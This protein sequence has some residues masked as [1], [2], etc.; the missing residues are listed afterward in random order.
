MKISFTGAGMWGANPVIITDKSSG[1][2][3]FVGNTSSKNIQ[4]NT[5]GQ[6]SVQTM[7]GGWSDILNA[8]D[9]GLVVVMDL[10]K[11]NLLGLII[12]GVILMVI[13][14]LIFRR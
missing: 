6:Y 1:D 13:L 3:I 11:N 14:G 9:Y 12:L 4:V 2:I 10:V 5:T 7:P 8:P